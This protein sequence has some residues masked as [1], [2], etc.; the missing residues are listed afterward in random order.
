MSINL[1]ADYP[2][3]ARDEEKT[4]LIQAKQGSQYARD[5]L[6]E[7][8]MPFLI[9]MC[10]R[11]KPRDM[12]AEDFLGDAVIGFL[13]AIDACQADHPCRISTF[14]R[15][16]VKGEIMY[17]QFYKRTVGIPYRARS[18]IRE[19]QDAEVWLFSEKGCATI[20]GISKRTGY[21]MKEVEMLR[22]ASQF[23]GD[24]LSL[25]STFVDSDMT[26]YDIVVSD[27][28]A[29]SEYEQVN[30]QVDL[31]YFLS[32]L[33]KR[34]RF[35]VERRSGIPKEMTNREIA[36]I[37]NLSK[38]RV[39]LLFNEAMRKM[40]RLAEHLQGTPEQV[41]KAINFPQVVM[42]GL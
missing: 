29:E 17:S 42:Q 12:H 14:A 18:Q 32:K 22:T 30:I 11:F 13:K 7:C 16:R 26:Y 4:L 40:Q 1:K 41:Q 37:L 33:S 15:L 8:Y 19:V 36:R 28:S 9:K 27:P 2:R 24:L 38:N 6:V 34:D 31:E 21:S 39:G 35:I 10:Y 23:V 3:L 25:D 20:K 5:R